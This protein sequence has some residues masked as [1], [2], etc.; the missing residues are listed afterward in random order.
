MLV[1]ANVESRRDAEFPDSSPVG[2]AATV[3]LIPL[4]DAWP[5]VREL[6]TNSSLT[7]SSRREFERHFEPSRRALEKVEHLGVEHRRI[8]DPHHVR[9][10]G[11]FGALGIRQ[12]F[13]KPIG[14][15]H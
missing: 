4:L 15:A 13:G 1:G 5:G 10:A 8:V 6:S 14:R 12:Q 2:T 7:N 3:Y 11:D 9:S